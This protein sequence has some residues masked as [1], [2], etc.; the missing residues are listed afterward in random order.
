MNIEPSK[1]LRGLGSYAFAEVKRLVAVLKSRGIE[2]IDFGVG[3]PTDPTPAGVRETCRRAVGE[4]ARS[5]YPPYVGT[6]AFRAGAAAWMKRRFGLSVDPET[7]IT[8]TIGSKEAVF[9]LPL[10]FLDPGDVALVPTPGYPP[11]QRGTLFAGAETHFLPLLPENGFLPDLDSVP[12]PVLLKAKI[13]WINYPNSPSGATAPDAFF[14]KAVA[15]GRDHGILVASDEAYSEIYYGKPP[16]SALEFGREGVLSIF[17][18]SKRSA[19]TNY[20][21]GW[22]AGDAAAVEAFKKMKTNIDSGTPSFIQDAAIAALE[23]EE[24][25]ERMRESYRAK[26]EVLTEAFRSAGF[27]ECRPEATLYV[28]QKLREGMTA[29]NFCKDLLSPEVALVCTPGPWITDPLPDGRNPGEDFVRF[30]LVP[31]LERVKE[32]AERIRK[33]FQ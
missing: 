16:R 2:P 29:E 18:L 26:M 27:P 19:M 24:H 4:R 14:E 31:P 23:D 20:R 13:L 33:R 8:S 30:A 25:V 6:V 17:S 10:A 21:V 3:D 28:W 32:A 15:F 5:G 12:A 1:K 22:V 9:H 7:E 11:Y